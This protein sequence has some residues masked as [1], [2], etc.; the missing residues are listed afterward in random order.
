M[1]LQTY[2]GFPGSNALVQ[3]VEGQIF[4][5]PVEAQV[6]GSVILA[7]TTIDNNSSNSPTSTLLPGLVLG[8]KTTTGEY[9]QYSAS[10]TDGTQIAESVLYVGLSMLD[11]AGVAA[12][13]IGHVIAKGI[14]KGNLLRGLDGAARQHLL[15]SGRYQFSDDVKGRYGIF[16]RPLGEVVKTADYTVVAADNGVLFTTLGAVGAVNFTLPALTVGLA[17]EFINLADQNMTITS[18]EGDNIVTDNDLSADSIAFSTSSH[19]INGHVQ[20]WCNQAGTKWY[21]RTF[22]ASTSVQ[23][24]AT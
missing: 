20:V 9:L 18:A 15:N 8:R 6:F 19:K 7:S 22:N 5:G 2:G 23:T 1:D 3:S 14:L 21:T 16:G 17:Y 11:N 10:A 4:D 13:K 12:Q 24:I